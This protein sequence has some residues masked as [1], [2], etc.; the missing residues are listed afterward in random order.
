MW[1]KTTVH[2]NINRI[3]SKLLGRIWPSFQKIKNENMLFR[4]RAIFDKSPYSMSEA[5]LLL[6]RL[7]RRRVS[8]LV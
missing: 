1:K 6:K 8:R 7:S 4:S 5:P 3:K 2:A